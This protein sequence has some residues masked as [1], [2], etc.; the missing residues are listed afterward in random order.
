VA[1]AEIAASLVGGVLVT[2]TTPPSGMRLER[3]ALGARHFP[4]AKEAERFLTRNGYC[5]VADG[6]VDDRL[7][8]PRAAWLSYEEQGGE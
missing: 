3:T 6:L 5:Y 7:M 4:G 2:F 1:V 8:G